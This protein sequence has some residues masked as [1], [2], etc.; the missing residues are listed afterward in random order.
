MGA[1]SSKDGVKDAEKKPAD[2]AAPATEAAPA[3]DA[4]AAEAP[5]AEAPAAEAPAA[6]GEWSKQFSW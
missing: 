4:P 2:G 3:G 6:G 5:A 1:C